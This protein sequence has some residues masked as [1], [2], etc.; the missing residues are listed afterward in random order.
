MSVIDLYIHSD[1]I[2]HS[3]GALLEVLLHEADLHL[4]GYYINIIFCLFSANLRIKMSLNTKYVVDEKGTHYAVKD[5]KYDHNYGDKATYHMTNLFKDSKELSKRIH[6]INTSH[7]YTRHVTS[8]Q[9]FQ[10]E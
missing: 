9:Y 10:K 5:Y 8:R 2:L 7:R 1:Y 4:T 3:S 6:N